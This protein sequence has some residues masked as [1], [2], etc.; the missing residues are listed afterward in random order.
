[1]YRRLRVCER[2]GL[3]IAD[4]LPGFDPANETHLAAVMAF[5][6]LREVEEARES[7]RRIL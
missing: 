7:M 5:E 2:L 6:H 4:V 3:A 1:M